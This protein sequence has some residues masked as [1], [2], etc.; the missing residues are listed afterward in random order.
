MSFLFF[1]LIDFNLVKF[2]Y[3]IVHILGISYF[4][5][6]VYGKNKV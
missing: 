6:V 1:V 4:S 5:V 2:V 3:L